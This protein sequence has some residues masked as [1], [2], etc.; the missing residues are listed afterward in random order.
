MKRS[1]WR[2]WELSLLAALCVTLC[3]GVYA[4]ARQTEL[5]EKI[6]RLHVI[7][8]DDS[9][10]E[11][12]V[13]REV[14][15]A[16]L[17]VLLPLTS[18]AEKAE[19][20]RAAVEDGLELIGAAAESAAGGRQVELFF[21]EVNYPVRR[22][23]GCVLPA[24]SYSSLRV[25]LGEGKG[26]NWWGVIFPDLTGFSTGD[27]TDAV[28][29]LGERSFA[30]ISDEGEGVELRFRFLEWLAELRRLFA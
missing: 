19:D 29:I 3:C 1:G 21:G 8:S 9:E 16:V 30:L 20:A 25:I 26:H 22:A 23:E 14:R 7:A 28:S 27:C 4:Q 2:I 11:Q 24:G 15:D 13:K 12:A 10:T 17:E 18:G 5:E 6:I